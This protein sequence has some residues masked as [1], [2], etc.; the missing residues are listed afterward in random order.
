VGVGLVRMAE[1]EGVKVKLPCKLFASGLC[2]HGPLCAF[3]H[4]AAPNGDVDP[5]GEVHPAGGGRR[6]VRGHRHRGQ[7]EDEDEEL[8]EFLAGVGGRNGMNDDGFAVPPDSFTL[9]RDGIAVLHLRCHKSTQVVT[10]FGLL[11]PSNSLLSSSPSSPQGD[12]FDTL[13]LDWSQEHVAALFKGSEFSDFVEREGLDGYALAEIV[14]RKDA[15]ERLHPDWGFA[16]LCRL[17]KAIS[18]LTRKSD[19]EAVVTFPL[20]TDHDG[21]RWFE[22]RSST[23]D[24]LSISHRAHGLISSHVHELRG[25]KL[26][27]VEWNSSEHQI[28]L[29]FRSDVLITHFIPDAITIAGSMSKYVTSVR[30]VSRIFCGAVTKLFHYDL[31]KFSFTHEMAMLLPRS[32][33]LAYGELHCIR[34]FCK[35]HPLSLFDKNLLVHLFKFVCAS[36]EQ[37]CPV[38]LRSEDLKYLGR[39]RKV[40]KEV[41]PGARN[42][43]ESTVEWRTQKKQDF[44]AAR[45]AIE[46]LHF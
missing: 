32:L 20:A 9:F 11:V 27:S 38:P 3:S 19:I 39:L 23:F 10:H 12:G 30:A 40:P 36:F 6:V 25:A 21:M 4:D 45:K 31:L 5:A 14:T 35:D 33:R 17:Y 24:H 8:R 1:D 7:V 26:V 37:H 46:S 2:P 43:P 28:C 15:F 18:Q 42:D 22:A 16:K 13:V 44:A 29:T 34:R 41:L